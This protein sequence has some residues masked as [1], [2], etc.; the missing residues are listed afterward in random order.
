MLSDKKI[1]VTGPA[2]NIG[3][4]LATALARDNEVWGVSRFGDPAER[5]KVDAIGVIPA[6]SISARAVDDL[7]NEFDYVL[8][9]D[10]FIFG[11]SYD[12]AIGER[13]GTRS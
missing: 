1:L 3:Y 5:A 4:P 9:L 8:D 2:G 11:D 7:P 10:A 6:R 13:R 12:Q